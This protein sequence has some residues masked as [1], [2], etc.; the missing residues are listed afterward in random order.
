MAVS[1]LASRIEAVRRFSRF[2]TRRIGVLE[3]TL[4]HSPFTLPEGRL[5]YEI[6]N[7]DRPT[8]QELCRDLGLDP[9]YVSR[10][11]QALEKRGCVARKRSTADKRQTELTLTAKGQRLWA[12]MNERSRQDIA[13]LLAELPIARQDRL[14]KALETVESLLDEPPEKRVPFTLRPHQPG[15]LGWII[16]RQTQL[17]ATEYGWDGTFEA[18]L[19]E[20]SAKFIRK[21]DP[22]SDNCW[23]AERNG[24]IAGSVFLVRAGKTTGQLRMLYVEPS[25]RGL[26]IGQSLVAAC[27][28]DA[29]AKGYKKLMLWTNDI[30]VSARKIY[31]AAGFRLI[32]EEKHD[33][34]G[35]K[36]VGQFWSLDL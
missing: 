12:A 31:I 26:G 33:S 17:Y 24:E 9:G 29:R 7:R 35:K 20:I 32:R 34:F 18:M 36:L 5:V 8:A 21:F 28:E 3:E 23:I 10:L 4:L 13:N 14:V 1:S 6:A 15:D 16:R 30:L 27:I 22:K 19:A 11:L 2:Y 25:A